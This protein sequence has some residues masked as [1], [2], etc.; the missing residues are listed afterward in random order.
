M[1]FNLSIRNVKRS[2]RD[3]AIYFLTLTF[4]VAIF[5]T[6][7][8]IES[9]KVMV[10]INSSQQEIFRMI[11]EVMEIFSR[12]IAV[13]LGFL[14]IYANNFL[15]KRRKK[16][17]GIY[18]TLGMG[19]HKISQILVLET[20]IIGIVALVVGVGIGIFASQGL[21]LLTA[22]LFKAD[23][24][25]FTFIFSSDSLVK[26]IV[27]FGIIFICVILFNSYSISKYKLIDLIYGSKKNEELKLQNKKT[28]LVI[29]LVSIIIL[30]SAY[31]MITINGILSINIFFYGSIVL[32][33]IG[34]LLLFMSLSGFILTI[35]KSKDNF[36][37]K[38]LN[39]FVVRQISSKVNTNFISMTII[40]LMLF[41]T[42]CVLSSGLGINMA[43]TKDLS[44][45]YPYDATI[46]GR[47]YE[48][49]VKI[50]EENG[51]NI[52]K[53]SNSY[54]DYKIYE[55]KISIDSIIKNTKGLSKQDTLYMRAMDNI[56]I[57]K[58]S[59]Y[60][61]LLKFQGKEKVSL[62]DNEYLIFA[63]EES[64][65]NAY[66]QFLENKNTIKID[67][68]EYNSK[69]KYAIKLNI[70]NM[71]ST[72][73]IGQIVVP[74]NAVKNLKI[75]DSNIVMKL[76]NESQNE[77]KIVDKK[78]QKLDKE[79]RGEVYFLLLTKE[80]RVTSDLGTSTVMA[81]LGIY[82]GIVFL[83]TSGA[84]L[85]LQQLSEATDNIERYGLLR[86]IGV[87]K[88]MINKALFSQIG[89]YFLLP[90]GLAIVHSIVGLNVSNEVVSEFGTANMVSNIILASV[91][92]CVVY[93]A[94]FLATFISA[95]NIIK[96]K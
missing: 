81:Y 19:K 52:G 10:G 90:L 41:V 88:S 12:F 61:N 60:N 7:N 26:T 25:S 35:I 15:I 31:T 66:K 78:L 91:F 29:F 92:I 64:M 34:T 1:F 87:D 21:S 3:Y 17:L 57:I 38:N 56:G 80:E 95:K 75:T 37:L 65:V 70:N 33:V 51:I 47:G 67:D 28:S 45:K 69:Y 9:Q 84:I 79:T 46:Y 74:D 86:K 58:L 14:V 2:F 30:G 93:G 22:K 42:I 73:D 44:Y 4:S 85:A 43:L 24:A 11:S 49:S 40:S 50:L 77:L 72:S 5:Y 27:C 55:S 13:I 23:L 39:L 36:Y 32:G 68:K 59:D 6:F 18:S 16:E 63:R 96:S 48:D 76:N 53:Y 94:Y 82:L 71:E 62:K 83:I 8:S 89:I 54:L 20:M